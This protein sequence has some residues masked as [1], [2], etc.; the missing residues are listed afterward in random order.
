MNFAAEAVVEA[1]A[2]AVEAAEQVKLR[3]QLLGLQ[4]RWVASALAELQQV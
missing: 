4:P 2:E 3:R 1:V